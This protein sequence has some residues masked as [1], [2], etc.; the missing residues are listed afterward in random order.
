MEC[1][2]HF[3]EIPET[4]DRVT[5]A[6]LSRHIPR[7][8]SESL[9]TRSTFVRFNS[10]VRLFDFPNLGRPW[11]CLNDFS[12][13]VYPLSFVCSIYF[14]SRENITLRFSSSRLRC[15]ILFVDHNILENTCRDDP[16]FIMVSTIKFFTWKNIECFHINEHMQ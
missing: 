4:S 9:L 12:R 7:P 6:N 5:W 11:L 8:L 3:D 13:K 16:H 1:F 15:S 2:S 14:S 10:G